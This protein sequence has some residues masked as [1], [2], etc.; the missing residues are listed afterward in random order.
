M[1]VLLAGCGYVASELGLRLVSL[2][3]EV[4]ALRRSAAG[5]PS[6]F[7][8]VSA[9][10]AIPGQLDQLPRGLE[11]V[12][13]SAS[14]GESSDAAYERAYVRGLSNL[15]AALAGQPLR[16]IFFTSSTSVY[17]Q[18]DGS[19]VDEASETS[20]AHFS[21]QRT[22]EAER[23]LETSGLPATVLRCAG[24]YGPGRAHLIEAVRT[25]TAN[26][27]ER[28]VNRIHRDDLAGAILH[29]MTHDVAEPRLILSDDEPAPQRD[30][31]RFLAR[32]LG[33]PE[34]ADAASPGRGG[35]KRCRND[36]LKAT[37]YALQYP[38]YREGYAAL[39]RAAD[40]GTPSAD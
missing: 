26:T 14:A 5:L 13:Y 32:A 22:L 27:S 25:G 8:A 33:V 40:P 18:A 9:D 31:A 17:A 23:V 21:G 3:A 35:H 10:L 30:I 28:Y 37:G 16:R 20:P 11:Y 1:K 15:I 19:W 24:I 6:A 36:R 7:H 12:V 38:T 39:L 4:W 29:L 2:G 34:P